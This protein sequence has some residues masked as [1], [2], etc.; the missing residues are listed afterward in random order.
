MG[1][2]VC[3]DKRGREFLMEDRNE[4]NE[5]QEFLENGGNPLPDK[6]TEQP[7]KLRVVSERQRRAVRSIKR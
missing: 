7:K 2:A 4:R 1:D 5:W 3:A 6:K